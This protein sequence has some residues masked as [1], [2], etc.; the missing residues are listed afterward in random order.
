MVQIKIDSAAI[1]KMW[2]RR[3]ENTTVFWL[4]INL[5][6]YLKMENPHDLAHDY[7]SSFWPSFSTIADANLRKNIGMV[8]ISHPDLS[9]CYQGIQKTSSL[10]LSRNRQFRNAHFALNYSV[11]EFT[12]SPNL[13]IFSLFALLKSRCSKSFCFFFKSI[14]FSNSVVTRLNSCKLWIPQRF[15]RKS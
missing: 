8:N 9:Y 12:N 11:S 13:K 7:L 4:I 3:K 2:C 5:L 6:S 15:D 10:F 14:V 1:F